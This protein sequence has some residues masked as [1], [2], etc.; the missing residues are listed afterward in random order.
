MIILKIFILSII[1]FQFFCIYKSIFIKK[2]NRKNNNK[3]EIE[4]ITIIIPVFNSEKTISKCL[5]SILVN[6]KKLISKIIIIFDHCSD[7]SESIVTK[8]KKQYLDVEIKT[9]H[10]NQKKSGKVSGI[11]K[12][13][14]ITKT[15][16][17]LL[18]DSDIVLDKNAIEKLI[19]FHYQN[20]NFY[21]SCYIYPYMDKKNTFLEN[22]IN[23]DRLYRQNILQNVREFYGLSNFPGGIGIVNINEYK[24]KLKSGFLEDLTATLAIIKSNKEINIL[25]EP[26][27]FEI[28]RKSIK[29]VLLQRIRW[30]IG[31]IE[32]IRNIFSAIVEIESIFKKCILLSYPIMW[33][34]QH[35]FIVIGN[36]LFIFSI[37]KQPNL[38]YLLPQLLYFT[39]ILISANIGKKHYE[40][41]FLSIIIHS[42][43]YPVI[44]TTSLLLSIFVLIKKKKTFFKTKLLFSRI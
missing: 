9:L 29:G 26:L 31:N 14:K 2:N 21:S 5:N 4:P 41:N 1:F 32:N 24:K 10:L 8:I 43:I 28:E 34:F 7:Q 35:Y 37:F 11:L 40:N 17:S 20:K 16:F 19:N 39:Q 6:K 27:A 22:I 33:Y 23:N 3:D 38:I 30:T 12:A 36:I 25:K 15:K 13:F 42:I 18:I 44:I